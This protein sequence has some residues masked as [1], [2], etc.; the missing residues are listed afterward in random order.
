MT[1]E[2][3][4]KLQE[5][6]EAAV[7]LEEPQR[8]AYLD[9]VCENDPRMRHRLNQLLIA[10]EEM[11]GNVEP[12][13]APVRS[14]MECPACWRCTE[15]PVSTCQRD[16]TKL[17]VAFAGP[18][19]MDGKYL[20]ERRLGQGGM[21]KVYLARDMRLRRQVAIKVLSARFGARFEREARAIAAMNHPHICA[22]YDIG[23]DYL[24]MEYVE[25]EPLSGP[26]PV[27][28]S[29]K[30]A[31]Q[32]ADALDAAHHRGIIHRDL[33]PG[34][35]L[36]TGQSQVKLVDFGIA[37]RMDDGEAPQTVEGQVVGTR[38]YMAPEQEEGKPAD[39]RSDIFSFGVT[40][41]ELL[42]GQHPFPD[43]T[44]GD[45]R[46]VI[47][48]ERPRPLGQVPAVLQSIVMRCLRKD[49]ADR[50]QSM[51][52][53]RDALLASTR[54]VGLPLERMPS[55]A[56]LPFANMSRDSD[57]EYFSDGLAEEIINALAQVPGF[58]VIA[59]TSAFVFRGK[60]QDIRTIAKKLGVSNVL[61]GSV[62]RAG[63]RLRIT[64][65]LIQ[66]A[67]GTHLWS[68]RYDR[69]LTDIFAIQDEISQ[70]ISEALKLRLVPRVQPAL[71]IEAYQL[72]LKGHSYRTRYK[73]ESQAKAKECFEKALAIEP[74]YASAYSGLAG[75]YWIQGAF[76]IKA[77]ADVGPLVKF[78][79]QRALAIDPAHSEAHSVLAIMEAIF[80]YDWKATQQ[81]YRSAMEVEHVLPLV[82]F[83]YAMHY[84]CPLGRLDDAMVQIRLALETDPLSVLL[85]F[86]MGWSK[87][88]AGQYQETIEYA[89]T[90]V[91]LDP[92]FHFGW[93]TLGLAQM[94]AGLTGEAIASFQQLHELAPRW[95]LSL[96]LFATVHYQA[97]DHKRCEEWAAKLAGP[98]TAT[99][100][101]A[102]YYANTGEVDNMFQ[103]LEGAYRERD[104]FLV[105]LQNLPFFKP[106]HTDSRY[107][108]L[109]RRMN[110]AS[111]AAHA[112]GAFVAV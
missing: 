75:F 10:D 73:P 102:V 56:V 40:L 59:R 33:K 19:L 29:L 61:E 3:H 67:D 64:A 23:P 44:R 88:L 58:K 68:H 109:L 46:G 66:A 55:I 108:S 94:G 35:I 90:A 47:V 81:H 54:A 96:G 38:G 76:G 72:Y 39:A 112:Q 63:N 17:Q 77:V 106:Y 15:S 87:Y 34:N 60:E 25:G 70:A 95:H 71:N 53:L 32:I 83:R 49:P 2:R 48:R 89:R 74:N 4:S 62:R 57:D 110:L 52:Q 8:S 14:V 36:V 103:A 7:N 82:R 69:D 5:I 107:E 50:F 80:A 111:R 65:Q 84:L 11:I 24:V 99:L 27:P 18:Q 21:G 86:V 98:P 93:F 16:G 42:S 45:V 97:G 22:L 51:A 26:L 37:R 31:L 41:Y 43:T 30:L 12:A 92:N 91:E 13:A 85:H 79:A 28:D 105:Y 1:P 6:F 20:V 9:Q 101:A 78:E 100:G 104:M